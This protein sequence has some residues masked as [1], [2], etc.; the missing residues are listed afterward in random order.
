MTTEET[1][2][3]TGQEPGSLPDTKDTGGD[4]SDSPTG[5]ETGVEEKKDESPASDEIEGS[6]KKDEKP[7]P[8]DQDPK[9]KKARAAEKRLT[10]VLEKNG[11]DNSEELEEALS[12]GKSLQELIGS[13]DAKKLIADAETLKKYN[14]YWAL[15]EAKK[16]ED[17]EEPD[18][19]VTRLKKETVDLKKELALNREATE[20]TE[21]S[22]K[23]LKAYE[24]EIG[25]VVSSH[26]LSKDSDK[27]LGMLLGTGNPLLDVDITDRAAVR[28]TAKDVAVKF[29]TFVK[30]L[31]QQAVDEYADGKSKITPISST[32]SAKTAAATKKKLPEDATADEVF[33]QAKEELMEIILEQAGMT[34]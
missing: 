32:A 11:F 14:E 17:D 8:Y 26:S 31:Q 13:R 15:E 22:K 10:E 16:Q 19:T 6:E 4:T 34:T 29:Q 28:Q 33:G 21:E 23:A 9:W 20:A 24:H 5:D 25:N 3:K 1:T 12:Q 27:I 30:T 7:A 18:E 2:E